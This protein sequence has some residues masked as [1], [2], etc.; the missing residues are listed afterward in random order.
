MLELV[1]SSVWRIMSLHGWYIKSSRSVTGTIGGENL[2]KSVL[3][4]LVDKRTKY[5]LVNLLKGREVGVKG[6]LKGV[7]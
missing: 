7:V 3:R 6:P 2:C 1:L 5:Y 4:G